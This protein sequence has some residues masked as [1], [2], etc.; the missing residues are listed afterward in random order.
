M[1]HTVYGDVAS[2]FHFA[3]FGVGMPR[4]FFAD[5]AE[6]AREAAILVLLPSA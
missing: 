1:A 3:E 4:V 6:I 5:R 2:G